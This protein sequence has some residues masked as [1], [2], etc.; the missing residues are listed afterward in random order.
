[1]CTKKAHISCRYSTADTSSADTDCLSAE[2]LDSITIHLCTQLQLQWPVRNCLPPTL[3]TDSPTASIAIS[4][5][6]S[7]ILL[8][9]LLLLMLCC[10]A[11]S[12]SICCC[13]CYEI[14]SNLAPHFAAQCI[15]Q[16]FM[17]NVLRTVLILQQQLVLSSAL[18]CIACRPNIYC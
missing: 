3:I 5:G 11:T 7:I 18:S 12:T 2:Q 16:F 15:D 17:Q 10:S 4:S 14:W 9:L 8:L 1:V 13:C 6:I